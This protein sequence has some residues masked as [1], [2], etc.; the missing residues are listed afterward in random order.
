MLV[1]CYFCFIRQTFAHSL[2]HIPSHPAALLSPYASWLTAT[3]VNNS[4]EFFGTFRL[5][6]VITLQRQLPAHDLNK[7]LRKQSCKKR[8]NAKIGLKNQAFNCLCMHV[9][10]QW[11][12]LL[13]SDNRSCYR[14]NDKSSS[15]MLPSGSMLLK[16]RAV[17]MLFTSLSILCATPGYWKSR[18]D[19]VIYLNLLRFIKVCVLPPCTCSSHLNLHGDL[20][21][22]LQPC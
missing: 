7:V 21:T 13:T 18:F 20:S 17:M 10:W 1:T 2:I 11:L 3:L 5:P 22:V 8:A 9:C 15:T 14:G 19:C 6:Y 16:L 4:L 12:R